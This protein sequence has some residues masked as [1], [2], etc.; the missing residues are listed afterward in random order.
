VTSF[1][2]AELLH[3]EKYH[4]R[5]TFV[6]PIIRDEILQAKTSNDEHIL[7][8]QSTKTNKKLIP[9][10]HSCRDQVFIFYGH[11]EEGVDRNIHFKRFCTDDFIT[12]LASAKSVITNGGFTLISEAIFLHKPLLCIPIERHYEQSLNAE[13]V[14]KLGYGMLT[15]DISA[16]IIHDFM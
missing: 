5:V 11:D 2:P 3:P 13:M 12:D 15:S 7:V 4:S 9:A 6:Q 16:L 14:A 1:F 8:Y 10:L